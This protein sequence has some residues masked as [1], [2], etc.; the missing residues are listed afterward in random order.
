MTDSP[1]IRV[2][3]ALSLP[4]LLALARGTVLAVC[5]P[6]FHDKEAC[7]D[8]AARL[9]AHP[10]RAGYHNAPLIGRIGMSYFEGRTDEGRRRY[11]EEAPLTA[12]LLREAYV[13]HP[14]PVESLMLQIGAAWPS[15]RAWKRFRVCP[16]S[17]DSCAHLKPARSCVRIRICWNGTPRKAV[18]G[19]VN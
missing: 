5:V 16:C 2:S 13:P 11:H 8:A 15:E 12:A 9:L 6:G 18:P 7:V 4:D 3:G 17:R 19:Q 1:L 14:D 10:A